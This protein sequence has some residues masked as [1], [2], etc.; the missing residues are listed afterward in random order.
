[1]RA[2]DKK[3]KKAAPTHTPAIACCRACPAHKS[4]VTEVPAQ[5]SADYSASLGFLLRVLV[6]VLDLVRV[7]DLVEE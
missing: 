5:H 3:K 4:V 6:P 7:D 1:L 2:D